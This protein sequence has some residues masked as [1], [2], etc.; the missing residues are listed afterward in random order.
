MKAK[1]WLTLRIT[2]EGGFA[3]IS[4]F[5]QLS[6]NALNAMDQ[7]QVGLWLTQLQHHTDKTPLVGADYQTV[8]LQCEH[9]DGAWEACFNT[10]DL[11][12]AAA[13][14]LGKITLRA[15]P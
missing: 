5:G 10:A 7:K 8:R 1:S 6:A 2:E 9:T 3:G 4:R 12:Q 13:D 14:I 11:P 15:L